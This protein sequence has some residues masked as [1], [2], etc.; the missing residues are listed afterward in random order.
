MNWT[1]FLHSDTNLL[2]LKATLTII[3][4]VWSKMGKALKIVGLL[5]QVYLTHDLMN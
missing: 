1:D 4:W 2:K 5:N 3:G